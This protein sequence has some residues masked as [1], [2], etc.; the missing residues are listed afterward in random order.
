M[1]FV[2]TAEA[3]ARL[4]LSPSAVQ[5]ADGQP[6]E[7]SG[8]ST[9]EGLL[10]GVPR[11][12]LRWAKQQLK[13]ERT[14]QLDAADARLVYYLLAIKLVDHRLLPFARIDELALT[15]FELVKHQVTSLDQDGD[16]GEC[17]QP[18]E[19]LM[20]LS[21]DGAP[22]VGPTGAPDGQETTATATTS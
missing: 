9:K 7:F 2:I 4:G 11:G 22:A 15:D 6:R 16:C 14:E 17:N 5:D 8:W 1:R 18:V 21:S 20:H 10:G 3:A 12:I 13:V 19:S